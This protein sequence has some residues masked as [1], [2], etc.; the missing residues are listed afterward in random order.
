MFILQPGALPEGAWEQPVLALRNQTGP[1]LCRPVS[2]PSPPQHFGPF[3]WGGTSAPGSPGSVG[4]ERPP[5]ASRVSSPWCHTWDSPRSVLRSPPEDCQGMTSSHSPSVM[6]RG[7]AS[8]V[9]KVSSFKEES[10]SAGKGSWGRSLRDVLLI[11]Q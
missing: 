8:Q 3:L 7:P 5:G 2:F 6:C 10:H 4:W 1:K 11:T 9:G